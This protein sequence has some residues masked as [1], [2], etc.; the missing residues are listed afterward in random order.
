[1]RPLLAIAT[2]LF[3][4]MHSPAAG[5]QD[6]DDAAEMFRDAERA[7]A[8]ESYL[9]ALRLFRAAYD[10]APHPTVRFHIARSLE[11]LGRL[12]EAWSEMT[13]VAATAGLTA[14][15]RRDAQ[16]QVERLRA[17]LV[18]LRVDGAPEGVG[19]LVDGVP[20]CTL[21]CE[22]PIDPGEHDVAIEDATGRASMRVSG[23]RGSTLA[24]RLVI[25]PTEPSRPIEVPD[26]AS[27]TRRVTSSS[28][29]DEAP[30]GAPS[31]PAESPA[32]RGGEVGWLLAT[33][34]VVSALGVAGVIAFGLH[35]SSL[36]DAYQV[37]P[38]PALLADGPVF[39][40]LTN[41]SIGVLA[42]GAVLMVIDLALAL[43]GEGT[44]GHAARFDGTVHF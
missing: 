32:R 21:P 29:D 3:A 1:M 43:A 7:F 13:E 28:P 42:A 24:V 34:S 5:A 30:V 6:A 39:V 16:R 44:G 20:M 41:A 40:D 8:S 11:R 14:P 31:P 27:E 33:G 18:T 36:H 15:Q 38:T 25:E 22:V 9:D 17:L 35:A 37:A 19:V 23:L 4:L 12:R 2:L 26:E 10:A